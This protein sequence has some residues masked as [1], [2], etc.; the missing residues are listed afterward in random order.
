MQ[1]L[2]RIADPDEDARLAAIVDE[3]RDA[4]EEIAVIEAVKVA[5]L[6][7]AMRIALRRM[8]GKHP[9]QRAREMELRSIAAEIG[10]AVRWSDRVAQ[11]RM[12]DALD[13]VERFPATIDA[14]ATGRITARHAAVIQDAGCVL[15]D[16]TDRA[17]FEQVVLEWAA[18]ETVARTRDY[19]RGL[20]E[21]LH[22]ESITTRFERAEKA[23]TVTLS[24]LHDGLAKLEI[25]GPT[26][27]LH[28]IH[29]RL[30]QQARAI[31]VAATHPGEEPRVADA[32][33]VVVDTEPVVVDTRTL[34]QIRADLVCDM[35][36]TGQPTI[37]HTT[38]ILPGGLGAIRASVQVT[39]PA[40]TAAGI[41]DRGASI[42]GTS[43]IDADTARRLMAT[44]PGWDRILTHPVTGMVLTVDRYRPGAI[45][46]RFLAARDI[47][48]RFPGCRQPAHRCDHD[49]NLDW[50][51][52]GR[53][54]AGNLA[55]LCKRHH[56]LKTETEWTAA[57]EPDGTIRW[58]SPLHRRYTDKAPPRVAFVPDA[59]PPPF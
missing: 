53:T 52:G 17:A 37:D 40:L 56:T 27:L 35:L 19:A 57:Q 47:H 9:T 38:D 44:A 46:E 6:A 26:A 50:A 4:E 36:L 45:L 12:S 30:T 33:P 22:P 32:E 20:A 42:D 24:E 13:L 41:F 10:A 14:L 21:H 59:D 49:H 5:Q 54:T 29:D 34:D 55:C 28:G 25:I 7:G 16:D 3:L 48:C 11:A 18:A 39:V 8:E 1:F 58:T 15:T 31:R 51:L 43:P 2:E 23:R